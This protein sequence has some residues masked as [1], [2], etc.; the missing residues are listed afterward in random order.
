MASKWLWC[1]FQLPLMSGF[2]VWLLVGIGCLPQGLEAGEVALLDELEAGAAA[3]GDVV[4]VVVEA[5]LGEGAGAVAAAHHGEA[6]GLRARLGDRSGAGLEA[7]VLEDPHR[8]VPQDRAGVVDDLAEGGGRTGTDVEALPSVGE[9][10]PEHASVA[11]LR[12]VSDD[13]LGAEADDVLG[14]QDLAGVEEALGVV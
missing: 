10:P 12:R 4:D 1:I 2:R 6:L 14:Q 7:G 11:T 8:A 9:A 3:G 13:A 5:E